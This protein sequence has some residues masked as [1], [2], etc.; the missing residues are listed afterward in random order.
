MIALL[1]YST[2]VEYISGEDVES[3]DILQV[4]V[5]L[6]PSL[7]GPRFASLMTLDMRAIR[8]L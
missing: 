5:G 2:T 3:S 4:E 6:N 8:M 1:S 7:C